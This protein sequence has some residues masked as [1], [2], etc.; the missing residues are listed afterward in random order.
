MTNRI[1]QKDLEQMV[2][3]L[4]GNTEPQYSTVGAYAL[5]YAYGGVKLIQYIN[6]SGAQREISRDGFGTKRQL[7][8]FLQGMLAAAQ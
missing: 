4:N 7:Y 8:G 5:S 2:Y 1:T 6:T 3:R